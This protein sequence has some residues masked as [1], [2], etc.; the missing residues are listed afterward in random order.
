VELIQSPFHKKVAGSVPATILLNL[1]NSLIF[2]KVLLLYIVIS[3]TMV[4]TI[5]T[6]EYTIYCT[7]VNEGT[8]N[9]RQQLRNIVL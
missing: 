9:V 2:S 1:N 6:F 3:I 8:H 4:R 7:L 5:D